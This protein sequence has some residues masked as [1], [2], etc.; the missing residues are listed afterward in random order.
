M[1]TKNELSYRDLKVTCN[2]NVFDFETTE[3]LEPISAGLGQD[4]GIK[5]LEFGINVDVKGNNL[6]IEGPMGVGRTMYTN[7]YLKKI[8]AKKHVPHDWCYIYNFE[9]PN[10]PIAVDL[11]AGQGKDF[12]EMMDGFIKEI[13][14]FKK[15]ILIIIPLMQMI[16]RKKSLC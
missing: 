11:P 4:R 13:N 7:N 8:A 16:L 2:T 10:E 5:A 6:Y 1:K 14:Q 15:I 12:K 9:N 3:E